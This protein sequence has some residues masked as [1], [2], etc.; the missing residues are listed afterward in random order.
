[1]RLDPPR[2]GY[3]PELLAQ[4]YREILRRFAAIPGVRSAS[5]TGCAPLEGCGSGSRYLNVPGRVERPEDR[6]RT[7]VTFVA[8]RYF[9]TLGIPLLAG[10]D[11][12]FRDVGRA[13]VAIVN[14]A[15]ARFYFSGVNPIGKFVTV[16]RDPKTGGWFG[17]DSP[18]E[19]IG[20]ATDVKS[21][22]L[23]D[24]PLPGIY[25]NMFQENRIQQQ[26][27]L[28]TSVDPE[29]VAAAARRM[30]REVLPG[31]PVKRA[32]TLEEQVDS[33]IVPERLVATLSEF[34]G[35]LGAALAGV[36][37]YGLLAYTVS[38]R[39]NEIGV[40]MALG[41]TARDVIGLILRDALG[42]VAAGMAVGVWLVWWSRPLAG[43]ALKDLR[44]DNSAPLAIG[45]V[46]MMAVGLAA[47][48]LP[49]RRAVRVDP[50]EALRYE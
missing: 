2:N 46:A 18:Y 28:R 10:R 47:A 9:E 17:D 22:E 48:Y 7:L 23:R 34:F 45:C 42:M 3:S 20:L 39:T 16:V 11:F 27:E 14:E 6:R 49:V 1:M 5:I 36:G 26:F 35:G 12:S 44:W 32:A 43:A 21:V 31:V 25:F 8:P 37:L 24:A 33:N 13:R 29:A 30:A 19:I 15:M 41:A 4:P 40:R 38:R 50:M